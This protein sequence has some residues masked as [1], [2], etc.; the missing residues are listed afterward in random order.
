MPET[1]SKGS[2]DGSLKNKVQQIIKKSISQEQQHVLQAEVTPDEIKEA[3][4][5]M[6]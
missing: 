2:T 3:M 5:A 6:K 1:F 4:F